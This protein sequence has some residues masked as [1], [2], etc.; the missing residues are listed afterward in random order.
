[1]DKLIEDR[2][3]R[4]AR[5]SKRESAILVGL[6]LGRDAPWE[7]RESMEELIRLSQT[8]GVGV[9]NTVI[10]K[11]RKPDPSYF[12]G[13]GKADETHKAVQKTK[14]S[15][16]IFNDELTP[17]Q[18][19]NLEDKIGTKIIDRPQLIMDIFAQ[20]AR[21]KEA[22]LQVELA[23]LEYLLP[24]LRGWG[25]A[26]ARLGGGIATRGPGETRMQKERRNIERRIHKV[27]ERLDKAKVERKVRRKKRRKRK[28]PE[29]AIIGYTNAG[30]TTLLNQ[31]CNADSFVEDKLFATLDS[32]V[33][34]CRLTDSKEVLFV[35]TV[36]FIKKLPT[37]LIPAFRATLESVKEANLLLNIM[38]ISHPNWAD[39]WRAV[40]E[41]L[42]DLFENGRR[43]KLLTAFN[44]IDLIET[45]DDKRRLAN[46]ERRVGDGVQISASKALNLDDL[47]EKLAQKLGGKV[48]RL[49]IQLP[50]SEADLIPKL[51]QIG[52]VHQENYQKGKIVVE[53]SLEED[54]LHNL[55]ANG[56]SAI[57]ISLS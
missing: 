22:K 37:Q 5:L 52:E 27:K 12:I 16:V 20:R 34:R 47:R 25:K 28:I 7:E 31:L 29:I 41:I 10:Q 21:S 36:G 2:I 18:S 45:Q 51:H 8:A 32:K 43:P 15:V 30:K 49:T 19:R 33:R 24:R 55:K 56:D 17:A 53:V 42:N 50:Y 1:M 46:A 57:K 9:L 13:E 23:Q 4:R 40:N 14:A 39:H 3:G 6:D 26:L 11:R 48:K 38:D 54:L 44:K 35:D